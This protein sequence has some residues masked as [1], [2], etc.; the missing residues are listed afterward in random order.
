MQNRRRIYLINKKY[1]FRFIA[2]F[3]F[4]SVLGIA[5][6]S[7]IIHYLVNAGIQENL[8]RSH[9]K[10]FSI[11]QIALPATVKIDII[12]FVLGAAALM[13][14]SFYYSRKTMRLEATMVEGL[15]AM[16]EG[17]LAFR[18]EIGQQQEFPGLEK[19][20]N[21]MLDALEERA[22][23]YRR[24]SVEIEK[25]LGTPVLQPERLEAAARDI[26]KGNG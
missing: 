14:L 2:A 5:A 24:A 9:L 4:L 25:C 1:Q 3:L 20:M 16:K 15:K 7:A 19:G 11:G 12:F 26:L 17:R 21:Q 10:I 18:F 23:G 22:R 13:L 6:S 8:Y